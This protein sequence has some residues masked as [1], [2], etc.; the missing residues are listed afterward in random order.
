MRLEAPDFERAFHFRALR[1]AAL[2]AARGKRKSPSAAAFLADLETACLRLE[3]ELL[4]GIW[5][6]GKY[7]AF[8]IRGPKPRVVSAAAFRDR[9]V[10]HALCAVVEPLFE[11]G[12][13]ADSYANRIGKGTHAAIDRYEYFG[14]RNAHVRRC[15][16]FRYFPA[17]D[18]A[19]L[20]GDLRRRIGCERLLG[21]LDAVVDGSNPQEPVEI[22]YPGDTL[23]AP[24]ERRRG[25]PIGD[26]TSQFF[27]NV[28]LDPLDHFVKEVLRVKGYVRYVDDFALFH[29]DPDT[30]REWRGR[31]EKFLAG[32]RLSPH[33]RKTT[34]ARTCE[35]SAFLGIV[36]SRDGRRR[37]P[38]GNVARFRGRYRAMMQRHKAGAAA[39]DDI[40]PRVRAWIA[41]AE[42][43]DTWRLRQSLF[44]DGPFDPS[45]KPDGL[46]RP[47]G[48][49]AAVPGTTIRGT[50][51]ARTA[52]GTSRTIT[53]TISA[54]ASPVR[55]QSAGTAQFQDRAGARGS[56]QG[57]S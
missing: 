43:A 9:V 1:A 42:H 19:I 26:L 12:F 27:A 11:R 51:A 53:T 15:D 52:T 5:R 36:L 57:P 56:V 49:F 8:E 32:R 16:I 2:R 40:A 33:P 29:D 25:L 3:R 37:L 34:M 23:W 28:Y 38:D 45:R 46:Q 6:P 22:H 21:V 31:I 55:F 20:K 17:I 30:L 50:C 35:P 39:L 54:S 47:T 24:Y 7:V 10:H 41:H 4:S 48:F 14:S 13:I 18:H 44:R